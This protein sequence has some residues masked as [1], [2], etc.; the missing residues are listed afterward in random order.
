MGRLRRIL[1]W[2]GIA[3][4]ILPLVAWF[5]S[6][7]SVKMT[8]A[9]GMPFA[10]VLD[11]VG[12]GMKSVVVCSVTGCPAELPPGIE[13]SSFDDALS[14]ATLVALEIDEWGRVLVAETHRQNAGAED[15][16]SHEYWLMDDLASRTTEDRRA[17][18]AKHI[19]NGNVE[20]PE[21]F[22]RESDR[23][24][25][26]EDRDGDGR[27]DAR[28]ELA[29]WND[30]LSGV[31]A[32]VEAREGTIYVTSIPSVYQVQDVDHDGVAESEETLLSGFGVKTSL[33]GHDLH[34]LTWGPDGKLYFSVGDRGYH[35]Q[36]AD[37]TVLESSMGPGRGAVFRMNADGSG[38][39]VFATGVRNPQELAFDD[40]GNLFTGD[41]NGD[42]GDRARVV[43]LVE[44][45]ET[46]WAMPFQSLAGDYIRGPWVAERLWDLQHETQ[47]AW[48]LPPIAHL[49]NGPAGFVH[50]PGLGLPERYANHFFLC[51]YAYMPGRSGVWSFAVEP[52][53]AGFEMVDSHP[54]IWSFLVTDFDFGWDGRM[55]ATFFDQFG[56]TRGVKQIEHPESREDPRLT[57]LPGIVQEKMSAKTTE[58]LLDLLE[59]PDQR[60]RLRAQFE[61]AAR[62]EVEALSERAWDDSRPLIPRIHAL[63]ALGQIGSE[64]LALG[65]SQSGGSRAGR[66]GLL[67]S[68]VASSAA[69]RLSDEFR[70]QWARVVGEAGASDFIPELRAGLEDPAP[71]VRFFA[72]QSLGALGDAASVPA[73]FDL[74]ARNSDEDVF[75][76]HG[77]VWALHR[78]GDLEAVWARAEDA[79]RS[80][81]LAV[82]LVLRQAGDARIAKFLTDPDPLLVVEAA[83]AIYDWPI[84]GAMD[85]LAALADSLDPAEEADT[86][87]GQALHRR[88]IGANVRLRSAIGASA[89]A[90]YAADEEQLESLRLIALESLGQYSEPSP[91][92]L[93]Q[94]FVRPLPAADPAILASVFQSEGRA[95]VESSVGSRAMEIASEIGELPLEVEELLERL[96]GSDG[97]PRD[98]MAALSALAGRFASGRGTDALRDDAMEAASAA[99]ESEDAGVRGAA[100]DL[101]FQLDPEAGV[102][103]FLAAAEGGEAVT[104]R[105]QA[106]RR[107]G[108]MDDVRARDMITQ[109]LVYWTSGDLSADVALE[110]RDAAV[111][112]GEAG[113]VAL[114][115]RA[116]RAFT[117]SEEKPMAS[118]RWALEGGNPERG[119]VTFQTIGDCQRC[120][121]LETGAA[122]G[123][124]GGAGPSL[125]G[126]AAKGKAHLLES[127]IAPNAKIAEGFASVV[128]TRTDGSTVA[129]LIVSEADDVLRLD[130]GGERPI[131]ISRE[132]I[133]SQTQPVTGMPPM[134]LTLPPH[135]LRDVIAYVETL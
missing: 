44:G 53:G 84:D 112:Q 85:S 104:D 86:Q 55:F 111:A 64:A 6:A 24:V 98:R 30:A 22:T 54:F 26:L 9:K 127:L 15:N 48:V 116:V 70:A 107:L 31:V 108:A 117:P 21:L 8:V 114:A 3:L 34:G 40:Y 128:V 46:G 35:L 50:Y 97:A 74:I 41:N 129:G 13:I 77:A 130:V 7:I 131:E 49:G 17:Y 79:D 90:R 93:T 65:P 102:R 38:L 12:A 68:G 45:G 103:A 99:L 71:R 106:W 69:D 124:G 39:E 95:L 88:V 72:A 82:L 61:L 89:L 75:L 100:R 28:S 1:K 123:H 51:D 59:F 33:I 37:G 67:G 122:G 76:R 120:H 132:S 5:G 134:G 47:P 63:W 23:L 101:L 94:G 87:T 135:A 80:V 78:I 4:V 14:E 25:V 27:A 60:V 29:S 110:V 119:R 66:V 52:S 18:Y 96:A 92:D 58:R 20:D 19:A 11:L 32:G 2:L 16:R 113:H 118:R 115:E 109:A 56:D 43:Y 83:R 81:R 126:V 91:R 62:S 121:R 73:L 105:Q 133:A 42:G 10:D 36:H 125:T 57:A